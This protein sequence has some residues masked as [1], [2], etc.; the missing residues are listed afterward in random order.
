MIDQLKLK[1]PTAAVVAALQE[2]PFTSRI[3]MIVLL[4]GAL[5][6]KSEERRRAINI[7]EATVEETRQK[8]STVGWTITPAPYQLREIEK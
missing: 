5:M 7:T 8:L 1:G 3:D 6:L 2:K 4:C